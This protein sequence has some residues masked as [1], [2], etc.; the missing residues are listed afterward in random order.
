MQNVKTYQDRLT[1]VGKK[2]TVLHPECAVGKEM[3]KNLTE[4]KGFCFLLDVLLVRTQVSSSYF[5][6]TVQRHA[7]QHDW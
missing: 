5:G 1:L 2:E 7:C 4:Q 6:F 3:K